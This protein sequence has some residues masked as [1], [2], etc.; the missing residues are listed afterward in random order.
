M[1]VF[2]MFDL[3]YVMLLLRNAITNLTK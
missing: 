2:Q 3:C 1:K